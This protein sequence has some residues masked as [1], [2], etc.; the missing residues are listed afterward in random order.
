[1]W[2]IL[3]FNRFIAQDVLIFFYYIGAVFMPLFFFIFRGYLI[4]NVAIFQNFHQKIRAIYHSLPPRSK[5]LFWIFA[6]LMFLFAELIWR[7]VFEAMIGYF[8]IH[9]YLYQIMQQ[10]A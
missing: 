5:I 7:M 1:M 6:I 9:D 8:D 10:R 4:K 2:D 3:T